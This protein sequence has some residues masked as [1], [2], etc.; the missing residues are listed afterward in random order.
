MLLQLLRLDQIAKL[1]NIKFNP[2]R[3]WFP[4]MV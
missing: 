3:Q 2:Y 4:P 1:F